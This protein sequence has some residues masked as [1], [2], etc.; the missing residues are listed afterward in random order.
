MII[1]ALLFPP[2]YDN[3]DPTRHS[4]P[5][6]SGDLFNVPSRDLLK[7]LIHIPSTTHGCAPGNLHDMCY[8]YDLR[9]QRQVLLYLASDR[10]HL[11]VQ[12]TPPLE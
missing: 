6:Q 4:F 2:L 1:D 5:H 3:Y 10:G 8:S 7:A 11:D 9:H 12:D